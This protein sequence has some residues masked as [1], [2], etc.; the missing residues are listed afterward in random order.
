MKKPLVLF[1]ASTCSHILNFHL[2]YLKEF[3][4][5][6]WEVHVACGGPMRAIPEADRV[7][8]LPFEKKMSSPKNFFAAHILRQVISENGYSLICTH[9]SLAAF[10]TK[11]AIYGLETKPP[12]INV[13]HGYLFD[14]ETPAIK[15]K[16][17]AA[18]EKMTAKQTALLLT[19]NKWD[20]SYAKAQKLAQRVELIPGMGVNFKGLDAGRVTSR[21]MK[22]QET[23][24]SDDDFV[25][26]YP[27]EFSDRKNQ[28]MLIRALPLLPQSVKLLLP[29]DGERREACIRLAR[30]LGVDRRVV[31]PGQV[32]DM[33]SWYMAA[34]AA[35]SASRSEGLPF[36]VMEAMHF[37]LPVIVSRVKGHTDL[38]EDGK[39]G[40]LYPRNDEA[41]FAAAVNVI[42][43]SPELAQELGKAA[44]LAVNRF[45][46]PEVMPKV[47]EQYLS[48]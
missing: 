7:F 4:R 17:L 45:S 23:G 21:G 41:A 16:M 27:A 46:L 1:T 13:V 12:L 36:N 19:M 22:R 8:E 40:L 14:N 3:R 34:D 30:S 48:V 47:M 10:F 26:I 35:V 28:A 18:A 42:L 33:Q 39:T 15:Q 37:G 11:T 9:T 25:L 38:I 31:L 24:L 29:G 44:S 32:S 43:S 20:Y 6:G 2:P 5:I